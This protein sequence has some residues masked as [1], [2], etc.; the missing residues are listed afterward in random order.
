[1]KKISKIDTRVHHQIYDRVATRM[2]NSVW[3]RIGVRLDLA[4]IPIWNR[5]R[6]N[7]QS[8]VNR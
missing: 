1:M 5:V 7:I 3:D 6:A 2:R 4:E 8:R